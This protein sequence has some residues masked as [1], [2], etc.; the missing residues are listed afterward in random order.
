MLSEHGQ[1]SSQ[2]PPVLHGPSCCQQYSSM[3][4]RELARDYAVKLARF[5][6]RIASLKRTHGTVAKARGQR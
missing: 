5:L 3:A 2:L 6:A 4:A 1:G